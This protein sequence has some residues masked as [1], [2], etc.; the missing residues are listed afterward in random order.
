MSELL[1]RRGL[2]SAVEFFIREPAALLYGTVLLIFP[3]SFCLLFRRRRLAFRLIAGGIFGICAVNFILL[4]Y[5]TA[6][7]TAIDF[8]LL[9]SVG[10]IMLKYLKPW[11]F[12]LLGALLLCLA[13]LFAVGWRRSAK[14][15]VRPRRAAVLIV[16]AGLCAFGGFYIY[17]E[18]MDIQ[19][20]GETAAEAADRY[21]YIYCFAHSIFDRGIDRPADYSVETIDS[22]LADI[23]GNE[24]TETKTHPNIIFLQ[25]ESFFDVNT[26]TDRS[27][28]EN[29]VPVF[30]ALEDSFPSGTLKVPSLATGTANTE[31][32]V[33]TGM[34]LDY[35]G[36]NEYP[37]QTVLQTETCESMAYNMRAL[38]Y[39]AH[40][41]HNHSGDFYDRN[42]V[43]SHLGFDTFTSVEYMQNVQRNSIGWACDS[44]L[45][46]EILKALGSTTGEDFI[47][48]ISV[49]AHGQYPKDAE[50]EMEGDMPA[51]EAGKQAAFDYY[52]SQLEEVDAFI[53]QLID[54][55]ERY[56]RPV[57]LVMYGDH[58]PSLNL[59]A[60]E[61]K[62]GDLYATQYVIWSNIGVTAPNRSLQAYQLGA[63]VQKL[64][65]MDSGIFTKLHQKMAGEQ[66]YQQ[67][68]EILQYDYLYGD[69]EIF[70]GTDP[71]IATELQMGAVPVYLTELNY[72]DKRLRLRGRGFTPY[73]RVLVDDRE[74][75]C[76]LLNGE[77][78]C[79]EIELNRGDVI[80]VAQISDSSGQRLSVTNGLRYTGRSA[81]YAP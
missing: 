72:E 40:A 79:P 44:V 26:L 80:R 29:P 24:S 56:G 33:L 70:E 74:Q 23:S 9:P 50:R 11:Q 13:V 10:S 76:Y 60:E 69:R 61:L 43:F 31:F 73:S 54:A 12:I 81:S 3:L 55:L 65:G 47:Y 66:D 39:T 38:G 8:V 51:D 75:D 67:A 78:I 19:D 32:E 57:V 34:S 62:G 2:L 5:R 64:L 22:I 30:S 20:D 68:L 7:L 1:C 4:F 48:A 41:I 17:R 35:F 18:L 6:P 28:D 27:F 25:L 63:Y 36:L 46:A 15:P 52:I 14:V 16:C 42:L 71:Y 37:Y 45:T 77:L 53:G 21:G 59:T 49:Q 58:L